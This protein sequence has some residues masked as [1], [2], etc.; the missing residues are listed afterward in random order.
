MPAPLLRLAF[1]TPSYFKDFDR[2][3]LLVESFD[4]YVP[5]QYHHY[6]LVPARDEKLFKPLNSSRTHVVL[7]EDVLPFWLKHVKRA[8]KFWLSL[9]SMPVRGW[10]IQQLVKLNA[11]AAIDADAFAC[12]DSGCFFVQPFDPLAVH[13]RDGKLLLFREQG[14]Q[15]LTK[16]VSAWH[17]VSEKLLG[18]PH[19]DKPDRSY[20]SLVVYF[21]RHVLRA[22]QNHIEA[23]HGTDWRVPIVRQ[24]T[25]SEYFLYGA[26]CDDLLKESANQYRDDRLFAHCH[27][28]TVPLGAEGLRKMKAEMPSERVLVMIN[29]KSGTPLELIREIF[30]GL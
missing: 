20:V 23:V 26:F 15:F 24:R 8:P 10:I 2:C 1:I 27:W 3:Q 28:G 5:R 7:Q 18:T 29:E 22:L 17:A 4:R 21:W 30:F 25:F 9:R 11:C 6:V 12:I 13:Y 14:P 19:L 16:D